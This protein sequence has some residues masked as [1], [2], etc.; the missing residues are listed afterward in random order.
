VVGMY[1]M[2]EES[3]FNNNVILIITI[4]MTFTN[5]GN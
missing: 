4:I 5:G 2:K 3:I 1:C